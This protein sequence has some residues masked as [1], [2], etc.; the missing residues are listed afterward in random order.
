MSK[1]HREILN[2]DKRSFSLETKSFIEMKN[3]KR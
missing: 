1:Y 2:S 3:V